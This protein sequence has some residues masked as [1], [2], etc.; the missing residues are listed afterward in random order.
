M[1][2]RKSL[3]RGKNENRTVFVFL[4]RGKKRKSIFIRF[5]GTWKKNENHSVFLF[6][7]R[8][9]NE[10]R[11]AAKYTDRVHAKNGKN[12]KRSCD[13]YKFAYSWKMREVVAVLVSLLPSLISV[14]QLNSLLLFLNTTVYQRIVRQVSR[15]ITFSR[16]NFVSRGR[17]CKQRWQRRY[18]VRPGRTR[19]WWDNFVNEVVVPEESKENFRMCKEH[20]LKLCNELRPHI[21]KQ[22]TNMRSP[23]EVERQ[24]SL[25]LYYLSDEERL[26]QTANAFELSQSTVS[27][28]VRRIARVLAIN[29]G[30]KYIQHPC[31]ADEVKVKVTNFY[32]VFCIPQ[33]IRAID[34]TH[35]D[36]KAP[37]KNPTG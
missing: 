1:E 22:T 10:N 37:T 35:I 26:R 24:V 32:R 34:C 7:E 11:M 27:I 14:Y 6:L 15:S 25:V 36:I 13:N 17:V 2:R 23:I 18:W 16:H 29:L 19:V 28:T 30:H 20:F 5:L 3:E 9:E 31:T 8:G 21:Q 4:V 33:C 12:C